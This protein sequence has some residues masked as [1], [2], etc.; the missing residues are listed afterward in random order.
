MCIYVYIY[1]H[2]YVYAF[3]PDRGKVYKTSPALR[4]IL[5]VFLLPL[6]SGDEVWGGI[7]SQTHCNGTEFLLRKITPR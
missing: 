5:A 3:I 4:Y 2:I 7:C 6:Y 1:A